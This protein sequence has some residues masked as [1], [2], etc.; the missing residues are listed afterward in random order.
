MPLSEL[1]HED[2][3]RFEFKRF[4]YALRERTQNALEEVLTRWGRKRSWFFI[5]EVASMFLVSTI[6]SYASL[7]IYV[8]SDN[9]REN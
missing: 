7:L 3:A 4:R 9:Y 2:S 5:L 8:R 1:M 6:H